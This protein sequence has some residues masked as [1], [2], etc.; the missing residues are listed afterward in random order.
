[1]I[2]RFAPTAVGL[3]L[4]LLVAILIAGKTGGDDKYVAYATFKDAGGILK[5]YNVKIGSVAA[6]KVTDIRLDDQDNAVVKMELDKGAAPIGDGA[7]AKVRPVNLLGEKYIDLDPGD[8]SRPKPEGSMIPR[9]KT[10]VPVELD[11]AINILDPDTRGALRILINEAGIS[12]AGRGADF[13]RTLDEMPRALDSARQVVTDID[14][15]NEA[16]ERAIV[17]GDRVI[18]SVNAGREDFAA[19]IDSAADALQ[20]VADRRSKLGETVRGAPQAIDQL[21]GTLERLQAAS[22][23]LT[24]AARDLRAT[25][26]ALAATLARSPQFAKDASE[27]L[28]TATRVAPALSKLGRRSTPTLKLLRPT[29]QRLATFTDESQPLI[30]TLDVKRGWID[31]ISFMNGWTRVTDNADGLG[32]HFRLRIMFDTEALASAISKFAPVP[33]AK[34]RKQRAAKPT[35]RKP[36][37]APAP[38][39]AAPS[40]PA[41]SPIPKKPVKDALE[42]GLKGVGDSVQEAVGGLLGGLQTKRGTGSGS[43]QSDPA[44]LLN[45]LLGP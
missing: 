25:T 45:Y 37:K 39:D 36:A 3:A 16:L 32:H 11:D 2:S 30:D 42:S 7:T 19:L 17:S 22:T 29:A 38:A 18:A 41:P 43:S 5:N 31:F 12:M 10:D 15:E 13:N 24:P 34:Q 8:L 6:G 27:T 44:K 23:Q 4:V 21:R 14:D 35:K 33:V 40:K 1:M 26:P 9:S 28:A 20:T